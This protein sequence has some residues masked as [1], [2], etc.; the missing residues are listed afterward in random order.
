M[1]NAGVQR[2]GKN[3]ETGRTLNVKHNQT[4]RPLERLVRVFFMIRKHGEKVIEKY[5]LKET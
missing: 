3:G 5:D 1:P 4:T 2:R